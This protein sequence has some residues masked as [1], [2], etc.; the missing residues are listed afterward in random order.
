MSES[1][2]TPHSGSSTTAASESAHPPRGASSTNADRETATTSDA[3]ETGHVNRAVIRVAAALIID[4]AGRLLLVRKRGT[5]VFM[6]PGGK[7]E[8]GESGAQT[9]ARE[10]HEEL[11]LTLSPAALELL[12]TF[13]APAANEAGMLVEAEVFRAA[14]TESTGSPVAGAEIDELRWVH[15]HEFGGLAIAPLVIDCM[16]DLLETP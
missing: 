13:T 5:S 7:Y 4:D 1:A 14:I 6:Q 3:K 8:P 9:L 10:L 16:L 2:H 12:G 11:G 15:P